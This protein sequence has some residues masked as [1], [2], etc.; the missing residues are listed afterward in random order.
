[1]PADQAVHLPSKSKVLK[2]YKHEFSGL[3]SIVMDRVECGM[4]L[5]NMLIRSTS[6]GC[7]EYSMEHQYMY[8]AESLQ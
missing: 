3:S 1:M 5:D 6:S 4:P 7:E 8:I 2:L